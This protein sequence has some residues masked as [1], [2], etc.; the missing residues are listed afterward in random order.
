MAIN[1]ELLKNPVV[2][3]NYIKTKLN[4]V[5]SV[6]TIRRYVNMLGWR[7]VET[8]YCQIVTFNNRVKRYIYS[9]CCKIFNKRYE[10]VIDIDEYTAIIR[11]AGY[12]NYRKH[13]SDIL[14]AAGGKIGRQKH[15]TVK[16]HIF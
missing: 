16:I 8:K 3:C 14:R 15:S 6:R 5:A 2:N 1:K 7:R 11:L 4:L 10:D 13:S 9:C 12:K